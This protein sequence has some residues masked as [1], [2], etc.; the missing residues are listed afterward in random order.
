MVLQQPHT[1]KGREIEIDRE[2]VKAA[3][4]SNFDMMRLDFDINMTVKMN[5]LSFLLN[6]N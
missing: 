5:R 1:L 3:V 4:I 2:R 6:R